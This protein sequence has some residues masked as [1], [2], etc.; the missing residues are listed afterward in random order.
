M[1]NLLQELTETIK[2][3]EANIPANPSSEK[4]EKLEKRLQGSLAEYFDHLG[5]AIDISELERIYYRNVKA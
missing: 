3:L 1:S 5:Q 2:S 4:S